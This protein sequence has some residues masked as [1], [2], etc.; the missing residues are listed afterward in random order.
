VREG[1]AWFSQMGA[2]T[3]RHAVTVQPGR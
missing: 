1:D 2:S 3:S